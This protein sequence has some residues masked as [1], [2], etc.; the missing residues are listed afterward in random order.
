MQKVGFRG[1]KWDKSLFSDEMCTKYNYTLIFFLEPQAC[2]NL[3][4]IAATLIQ[5]HDEVP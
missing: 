2:Y 5:Q 1:K 3:Y 4:S